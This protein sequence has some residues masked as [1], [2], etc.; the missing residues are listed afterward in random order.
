MY[1]DDRKK[2]ISYSI[3][4]FPWRNVAE[5][6][7]FNVSL[8]LKDELWNRSAWVYIQQPRL[9]QASQWL[10][11]FMMK[12]ITTIETQKKNPGRVNIHLDGQYA[13]GL[14][15]IVAAWLSVGQ[16]LSDEKIAT[17]QMDDDREIAMQKALFFL[18]YRARSTQEVRANLKKHEIPEAVIEHTLQ[19]LQDTN[20]L[21]DQEFA[22]A[23]LENRNTFRPRSKR[24][25]EMELR[26]KGLDPDLVQDVISE[27]VDEETL[28]GQA[29]RKY[30]R[31][32]QDLPWQEFRQKLSAHLGRRGFTYEVCAPVVRL[33][34]NEIHSTGSR[35][36]INDNDEEAL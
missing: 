26:H 19:R 1:G 32:V 28:A 9:A 16:S 34:W 10:F 20:L 7:V 4:S 33:I 31:K 27:N 5:R 22:K 12:K 11:A 3:P 2:T 17:L 14:S 35:T 21:N 29:A 18:G 6:M 8:F 36:N 24:M 13:F 15:R 23:W 25:I 30:L